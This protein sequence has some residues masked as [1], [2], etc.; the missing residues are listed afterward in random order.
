MVG[1]SPDSNLEAVLKKFVIESFSKIFLNNL[2]CQNQ[3]T[4]Q[5]FFDIFTTS[6]R[7]NLVFDI[8]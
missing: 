2:T 4:L 8:F 7:P 6:L 5:G 1:S 3:N